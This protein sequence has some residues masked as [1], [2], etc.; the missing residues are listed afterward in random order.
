[1]PPKNQRDI[2]MLSGAPF[3]FRIK[4][5]GERSWKAALCDIG[6]LFHDRFILSPID[7]KNE[8]TIVLALSN[9]QPEMVC[10]SLSIFVAIMLEIEYAVIFFPQVVQSL[11]VV[12]RAEILKASVPIYGKVLFQILVL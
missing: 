10:M 3:K 1:M 11:Q 8:N 4:L 12:T 7:A 9:H 5:S 2:R 6:R